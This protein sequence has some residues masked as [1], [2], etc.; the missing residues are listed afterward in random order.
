MAPRACRGGA[1]SPSGVRRCE[2]RRS[3]RD[4]RGSPRVRPAPT[5]RGARRGEAAAHGALHRRGPA[6]VGPGAGEE[7][8]RHA[9]LGARAQAAR[10]RRRA[11]RRRRLAGREEALEHRVARRGQQRAGTRAR[12]ARRSA[13]DDTPTQRSAADSDTARYWPR[14]SPAPAVRSKIH[15]SGEPTAAPNSCGKTR[16]SQHRVQVHD[17]R[18]AQ[19]H[20]RRPGRAPPARAEAWPPSSCGAASTIASKRDALAVDPERAAPRR[21]PRA[22]CRCTR[23][24]FHTDAPTFSS[25]RSAGSPCT[26]CERHRGVADVRR[27]GRVE[28]PRLEHLRARAR[29]TPRPRAGSG[30]GARPDPRSARS[31][32]RTGRARAAT[33]RSVTRVAARVVER[34]AT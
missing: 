15:S 26:C 1:S 6:G 10:V 27:L 5:Q 18:G 23:A 32:A 30:S 25:A 4:L 7:Q 28:E 19:R 22:R 31:R 12:S 33:R 20:E 2:R 13:S 8:V 21:W 16:R 14:S 34:D 3:C 9:R 11:E 17:R 24:R 29:A